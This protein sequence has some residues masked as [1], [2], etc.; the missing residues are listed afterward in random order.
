MPDI[1]KAA[2]DLFTDDSNSYTIGESVD[3]VF[4]DIQ[5]HVNTVGEYANNNLLTV[6]C[7]KNVK[8][9]Y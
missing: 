8:F 9:S 2:T 4:N 1:G 5:K 7:P 3:I 6:Q